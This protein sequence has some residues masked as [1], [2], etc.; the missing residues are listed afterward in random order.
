MQRKRRY[1]LLALIPLAVSGAMA[2]GLITSQWDLPAWMPATTALN[3]EVSSKAATERTASKSE[4]KAELSDANTEKDGPATRSGHSG[5]MAPPG[6]SIDIARI[7]ADGNSVIAGTADPNTTIT[8]FADGQPVGSATADQNGEWVLI[9]PHKFASLDP[10]LEVRRGDLMAPRVA[11]LASSTAPGFPSIGETGRPST[12]NDG[13]SAPR[14]TAAEI[15]RDMIR[16]IERLTSEANTK[17]APASMVSANG[18]DR[19][20]SGTAAQSAA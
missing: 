8:I 1:L 16:R 10:K 4:I 2:A 13:T 18:S 3:P 19:S 17:R 15:T 6:F 9:T 20:N 7:I 11:A 5:Q 12:L 14:R